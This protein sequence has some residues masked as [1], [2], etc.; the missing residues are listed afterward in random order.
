[1]LL[2]AASCGLRRG[3]IY[4]LK[5]GDFDS[6]SRTVKVQRSNIA[7]TLTEP[8]TEAGEREV[9][10]FARVRRELL[11]HRLRSSFKAADDLVFPD[12]V[13]R[14]QH[15]ALAVRR[16]LKAALKKAGLP[17]LAF[18]FHALRHHAVSALIAEGARITLVSKVAGHASPDVTLR[19]YSHLLGE[20]LR[21]AADKYDPLREA[22]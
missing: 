12:P 4:G 11:A 19:V 20:D 17:E 1:M 22:V 16:E 10:V 14:P 7:G 2:F 15:P 8:K 6:D 3:E 21:A 18:R 5:W 9:P 13:G